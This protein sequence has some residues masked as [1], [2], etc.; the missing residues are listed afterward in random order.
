VTTSSSARSGTA[1]AARLLCLLLALAASFLGARPAAAQEEDA[2][3]K[4]NRV[5]SGV[6]V[7]R[8]YD[9]NLKENSFRADFYVWFRW[10]DSSLAPGE[11]FEVVN[12]QIDD[13]VQTESGESEGLQ[14]AQY[15]VFATITK[16]WDVSR[17]PLDRHLVTIEIEDGEHEIGDLL[18]VPD[19]ANSQLRPEVEIPG[20]K[21]TPRPLAAEEHV[22]RTNYGD[23]TLPTGS[24]TTYSRLV[25][26]VEM[27]RPGFGYFTKLF[28]GL[29]MAVL[30]GLLCFFIRP[31]NTSPRFGVGIGAIFG[32]VTSMYVTTS[33][34]PDTN[35]ITMADELHIVA[36]ATI[37]AS[38]TEST[39]SLALY[40][41]GRTKF[42]GRMDLVSFFTLLF[43][44]LGVS[45]WIV[46]RG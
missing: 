39:A 35:L 9:V 3:P 45:A 33:S 20:W 7:T 41:K 1:R 12:G 26:P 5:H 15:R 13:R 29:L 36:F 43:A 38:M 28:F 46:L 21:L 6:Y 4:D 25:F 40:F 11:T 16:F 42:S 44:Y 30:T 14:Y 17:F 27:T 34:L 18:Y 10:A 23:L 37:F 2:G 8:I 31:T 22:Y 32:A 19:A 24:P